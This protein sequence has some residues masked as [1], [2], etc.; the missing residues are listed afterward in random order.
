VIAIGNHG[1]VTLTVNST[2]GSLAELQP[3]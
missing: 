2:G 3:S 1:P